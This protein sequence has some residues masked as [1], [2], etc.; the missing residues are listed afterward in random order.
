MQVR[1]RYFIWVREDAE[2]MRISDAESEWR[3]IKALPG[4]D[5]FRDEW[6]VIGEI[7][8][9]SKSGAHIG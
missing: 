8:G 5:S 4:V 2:A 1:H 9:E 3:Y 6:E 7:G